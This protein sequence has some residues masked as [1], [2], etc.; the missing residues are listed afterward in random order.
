[1]GESGQPQPRSLRVSCGR[2]G[3]ALSRLA[4]L[5]GH[6]VVT[7][8]AADV[9]VQEVDG[10]GALAQPKAETR[11]IALSTRRLRPLERRALL[12]AGAHRVLDVEAGFLELAFALNELLFDSPREGRRYAR[13]RGGIRVSLADPEAGDPAEGRLMGLFAGGGRLR[14]RARLPIGQPLSLRIQ[15]G[16]QAVEAKGR[17]V[18]AAAE[19]ELGVDFSLGE[20]DASPPLSALLSAR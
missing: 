5:Q 12:A 10:P 2:L 7:E 4:E 8:G 18:C 16:D 3:L 6:S 19:D 15:L 13:A 11:V 20:A 14:T 17:V 1:M 9:W